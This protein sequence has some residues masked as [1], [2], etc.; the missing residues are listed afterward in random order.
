MLPRK[1]AKLALAL[2]LSL[3][4]MGI[5]GAAITMARLSN[6]AKWVS[7]SYQVELAISNVEFVLSE[8]A[9]ARL[10]YVNSGDESFVR[11]FDSK[12]EQTKKDGQDIRN[13]TSDNPTQQVFCDRLEKLGNP[14]ME[15]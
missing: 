7:H 1:R 11:V 6:S 5:S 15:I 10:N 14:R 3:V 9:R 8:A 12:D 13:L 2:A 4:L